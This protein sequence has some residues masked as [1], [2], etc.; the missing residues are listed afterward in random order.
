MSKT[1]ALRS[2]VDLLLARIR[3]RRMLLTPEVVA[4][5]P[6]L[7]RGYVQALIDVGDVQTCASPL[8][9]R[10]YWKYSGFGRFT[11]EKCLELGQQDDADELWEPLWA[12]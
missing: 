1:K 5:L 2:E 8:W 12:C 9:H 10:K 11:C 7:P 6:D 4:Q 3:Q